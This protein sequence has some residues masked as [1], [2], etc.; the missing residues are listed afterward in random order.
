MTPVAT[1]CVSTYNRAPQLSRLLEALEAQDTPD[2]EVVVY[3]DASTDAT[4]V[5]IDAWRERLRLTVLTGARNMGPAS[6]RNQAWQRASG[7]LVLFTDDDCL[8]S[9]SWVSAHLAAQAPRRVTVGRTEPEPGQLQGPFSRTMQVRDARW[10][11]TCNV[12]YPRALLVELGGFDERFRRAAG[13]DTELGLRAVA[14]G[15]EPFF[16]GDA[17]VHHEVRPSSWRAAMREA[18]KW[19]DLPLVVA[20][21][22][23]AVALLHS[24][25]SWRRS[26]PLALLASA[27]VLCARRHP[28]ALLATAPWLR[29]RLCVEPLPAPRRSLPWVL[30]GQ[31][32]V[33]LVEVAALLRGSIRHRRLLL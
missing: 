10:F 28:A 5:V 22:P 1:V 19:S 29:L 20:E 23:E 17:V 27:G 15:A 30:P 12:S 9:R 8:P 14:A 32:A 25:W 18:R 33:D 13:E 4:P 3:D 6:G 2:V 24:R 26:H 21:H 31:L 7:D 16:A 11:Q